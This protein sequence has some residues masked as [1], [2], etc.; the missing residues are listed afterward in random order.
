VGRLGGRENIGWQGQET[1]RT[2][3]GK[4]KRQRK[5]RVGRPRDREKKRKGGIGD[6]RRQGIGPEYGVLKKINGGG[7]GGG[8]KCYQHEGNAEEV[9]NGY[10]VFQLNFHESAGI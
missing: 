5:H 6:R 1:E 7:G 4:D 2:W 3:G 8:L 10:V 9:S